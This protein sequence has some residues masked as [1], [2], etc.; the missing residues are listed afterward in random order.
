MEIMKVPTVLRN[1]CPH[2]GLGEVVG[3]P[4]VALSLVAPFHVLI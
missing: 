1:S 2:G 4:L 3:G